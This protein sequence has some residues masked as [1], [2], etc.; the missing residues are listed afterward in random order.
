MYL[1]N[2][3]SIKHIKSISQN[4]K[5]IKYIKKYFI[6]YKIDNLNSSVYNLCKG[7]TK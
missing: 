7:D 5:S 3:K 6:K 1:Q 2:T 4:T